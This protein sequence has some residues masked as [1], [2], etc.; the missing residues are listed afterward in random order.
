[1]IRHAFPRPI[2]GVIA[3][4]R[5]AVEINAR[6]AAPRRASGEA[7]RVR[8]RGRALPQRDCSARPTFDSGPVGRLSQRIVFESGEVL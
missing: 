1:M 4:Q 6:P 5:V 7:T 2:S 8:R 3:N